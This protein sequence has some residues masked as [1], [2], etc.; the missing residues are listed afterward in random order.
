[1]DFK[2]SL[3]GG[4]QE[5]V[6]VTFLSSGVYADATGNGLVTIPMSAS[7]SEFEYIDPITKAN[8]E[9]AGDSSMVAT[10]AAMGINLGI[11]LVFSGSISAMWT[12]VNTI[13]L[14]SL[15]PLCNVNWPQITVLAF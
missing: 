3:K 6:L 14:V 15:L 9:A 5:K 11:S 13:Q 10:F 12:M 2:S 7:L 4:D 8:L 1:M